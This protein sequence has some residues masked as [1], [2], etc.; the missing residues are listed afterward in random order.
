MSIY[1][2]LSVAYT[3]RI[4]STCSVFKP[5]IKTI[6][7]IGPNADNKNVQLGN[8]NGI[9]QEIITARQGI[10]NKLGGN[11][12]VIYNAGVNY[13]KLLDGKSIESVAGEASKA[14]VIIFVGGIS[15]QLEGEEGD[16]GKVPTEGF[17]GGDRTTIGK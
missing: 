8:Y 16:A 1:R 3:E 2:S 10:K 15:P 9:P 14:D 13:T 4:R 6:A 17:N 11:V 12:K 5:N 7:I